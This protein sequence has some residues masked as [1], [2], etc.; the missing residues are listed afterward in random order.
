MLSAWHVGRPPFTIST[1]RFP[2]VAAPLQRYIT[3][4]MHGGLKAMFLSLY[5]HVVVVVVGGVMMF[6]LEVFTSY[7]LLGSPG[8]VRHPLGS[9]NADGHTWRCIKTHGQHA[10]N[11]NIRGIYMQVYDNVT[12]MATYKP[13]SDN[14]DGSYLTISSHNGLVFGML[15]VFSNFGTVFVDN[16]LDDC[17]CRRPGGILQ[18]FSP[19]GP[20][21]VCHPFWVWHRRESRRPG[22]GPAGE[23]REAYQGLVVLA[24]ATAIWGTAGATWMAVICF[25]AVTTTG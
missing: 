19:G 24:L 9:V 15:N 21:L 8:K 20:H 11:T 25:M 12:L 18:G 23:C 10:Q 5:L 7:S 3:Y 4:I 17:L 2:H 13:V 22:S 16:V 1:E 6:S 14:T